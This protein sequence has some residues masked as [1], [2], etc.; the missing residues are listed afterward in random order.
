MFALQNAQFFFPLLKLSIMGNY[1]HGRLSSEESAE[2]ERDG[3]L[4]PQDIADQRLPGPFSLCSYLQHVLTP[5][6]WGDEITLT[7]VSMIWQIRVTVVYAET[8]L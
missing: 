1:G 3:T 2:K 5:D 4:T 7:L 8:L 6:T